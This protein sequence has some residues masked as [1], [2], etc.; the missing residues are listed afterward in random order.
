[1]LSPCDVSAS[2]SWSL[3][4]SFVTPAC[5]SCSSC[6]SAGAASSL[7]G[8][9]SSAEHAAVDA[10]HAE[11]RNARTSE[12][13]ISSMNASGARSMPPL[14]TCHIQHFALRS[15]LFW[16][17]AWIAAGPHRSVLLYDRGMVLARE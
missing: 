4:A 10:T 1:M 12:R 17:A 8:A 16:A 11:R 2:G 5:T 6:S 14:P 9:L 3:L 13:R 15:G 7:E